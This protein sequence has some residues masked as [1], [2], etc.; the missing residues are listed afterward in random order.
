MKKLLIF[1]FVASIIVVCPFPLFSAEKINSSL[2]NLLNQ[3]KEKKIAEHPYWHRLL[4]YRRNLIGFYR[5]EIDDQSF[6]LARNGRDDP[7]AEL[8]ATL[9]GFYQN[10][11][12]GSEEGLLSC[13]YKARFSWLSEQLD[14]PDEISNPTCSR[15]ESWKEKLSPESAS[16]IF[17]S[18]YLNNPASMYGHTF[19]KLGRRGFP[20]EQNL[21]DYTVNYA[22]V[23]NS[24]NGIMFAL[25]GLTGG[26]P[27]RFSTTPYYIQI[28]K[29]NNMESRDLWEYKLNLSQAAI[30]RLV[31]HLWELGPISM[32]YYFLNKNCS[33]QLFPLLEVADPSLDIS[34]EYVMQTVPLDTLRSVLDKKGFVTEIDSRPSHVKAM[35]HRRKR[36]G[37]DEIRLVEKI[38]K[39]SPSQ[40]HTALSSLKENRRGYV[41]QSAHDLLR[42]KT[43][44]YRDQ[45]EEVKNKEREIL[46]ALNE[47]KGIDLESN[48]EPPNLI[49]PHEGHRSTR[50][51]LGWGINEEDTF[52]ELNLRPA[53]HD[54]EADPTGF[55]EGSQLEMFHFRLRYINDRKKLNLEEFTLIEIL[56]L[57]PYDRWVHPLSWH[58]RTGAEVARDLNLNSE[59]SLTYRLAGGSGYASNFTFK[60][61]LLTYLLWHAD[62][63]LGSVF[64]DGYRVGLGGKGGVVFQPF[65]FIRY[66][67]NS[68]VA[69]YP[70]GHVGN[71]VKFQLTQ[72][73][74]INKRS[75]FRIILERQ[76][77]YKEAV[78]NL[79]YY[80]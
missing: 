22:A 39:S 28:Q 73:I 31:E 47:I 60:N 55:D 62:S 75:E 26:Y 2:Q 24:N 19:L 43:G 76:N 52:E 4:H 54:L 30:D 51:G 21:M 78:F 59:E 45:P 77:S 58:V 53:L 61:K 3:A 33:Y 42:Y 1:I 9:K 6:F 74:F 57:S 44:F 64:D 14:F 69:R 8:E 25:R 50:L 79:H 20:K 46:L 65:S 38:V 48:Y 11:G 80:F 10:T 32:S 23:T 35:L 67:F 12:E 15:F 70:T 16:L 17:S 18:F 40:Y 63:A 37:G 34:K 71:V 56:S 72:N 36:I 13:R 49:P 41:L 5:S 68:T 7:E 66:H 27:G 29:Y